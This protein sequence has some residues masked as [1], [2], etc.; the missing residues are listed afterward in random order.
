MKRKLAFVVGM[1]IGIA[2]LF[3]YHAANES[4]AMKACLENH[5]QDTC[6]TTLGG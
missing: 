1:L 2:I 5:S 6:V 3:A 4:L